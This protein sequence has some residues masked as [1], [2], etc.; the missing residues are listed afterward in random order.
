MEPKTYR[1]IV[2]AVGPIKNVKM[3]GNLNKCWA[4]LIDIAIV[5]VIVTVIVVVIVVSCHDKL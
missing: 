1:E 4:Q 2:I 3:F 5:I